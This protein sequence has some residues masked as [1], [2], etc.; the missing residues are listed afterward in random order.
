MTA[1]AHRW[2]CSSALRIDAVGRIRLPFST[3]RAAPVLVLRQSAVG[4]PRPIL[5]ALQ[6]HGREIAAPCQTPAALFKTRH[7]PTHRTQRRR[8]LAAAL[9][10]ALH[11][12]AAPL[13]GGLSPISLLLAQTDWALH[14]ATQPAQSLRL[15][16]DAQR[17]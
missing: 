10:G 15:A 9:D 2:F 8:E 1:M 3:T 11:A 16:M 5:R 14:L 6:V 13:T 7:S 4:S 17:A 12:A